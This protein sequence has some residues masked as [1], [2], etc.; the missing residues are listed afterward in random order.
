MCCSWCSWCRIACV[1]VAWRRGPATSQYGWMSCALP[2]ITRAQRHRIHPWDPRWRGGTV[3][4]THLCVALGCA[5]S[6]RSLLNLPAAGLRQTVGLKGP[7][8]DCWQETCAG[9]ASDLRPL[10]ISHACTSA[11]VLSCCLALHVSVHQLRTGALLHC[12]PA[13][14]CT[15][16]VP[17]GL[18]QGGPTCV[19]YVCKQSCRTRACCVQAPITRHQLPVDRVLHFLRTAQDCCL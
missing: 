4:P 15:A 6:W 3:C 11:S 12:L 19:L 18:L 9:L 13:T 16:V 10:S 5:N 14:C 1:H 2:C 8:E 7:T 17:S